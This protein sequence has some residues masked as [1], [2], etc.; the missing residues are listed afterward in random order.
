[1]IPPDFDCYSGTV[2]V[3]TAPG[4]FDSDYTGAGSGGANASGGANGLVVIYY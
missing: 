3:T 2:G 1:M 4:S